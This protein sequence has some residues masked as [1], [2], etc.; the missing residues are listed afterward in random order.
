M[1]ELSGSGIFRAV[2]DTSPVAQR[3]YE[4]LLR[5]R[6]PAQR[7]GIAMSLSRA[8]RTMAVAGIRAAYPNA[9]AREVA[10]RLAARMYG[11]EVARRLF[12]NAAP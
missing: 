12:G 9:S 7:L 11:P 3:R 2:N 4:E 8:V 1:T 10:A 6:T 5:E